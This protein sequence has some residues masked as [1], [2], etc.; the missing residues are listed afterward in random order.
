M[1]KVYGINV[2]F[3]IDPPPPP[4]P[5]EYILYTWF[6]GLMLAIMDLP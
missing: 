2:F 3:S 5:K 1:L 4:Q 6:N